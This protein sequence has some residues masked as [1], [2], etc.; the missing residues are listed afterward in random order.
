MMQ[1]ATEPGSGAG[2][3]P[4][5]PA[6]DTSQDWRA[7]L[8]DAY[9]VKDST[10]AVKEKLNLRA[11]PTLAKYKSVEELARGHIEATKMIGAGFKVPGA[12]AAPAERRAFYDKLGVPKDAAG[13]ADVKAPEGIVPEAF[14]AYLN[15]VALATGLTPQQ[16]QASVNFLAEHNARVHQEQVQRWGEAQETLRKEWGLNFDRN[17]DISARFVRDVM[18]KAG[19][20]EEGK[21]EVAEF[22]R[23]LD[24]VGVGHHPGFFRWTEYLAR[25]ATEDVFEPG[26]PDADASTASQDAQ[27]A[28]VAGKL[29]KAIPGTPEYATLREQHEALLKRRHGTEEVSGI[30]VQ[31]RR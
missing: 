29:W 13:Y 10:G 30:T 28:E 18:A 9:E 12:D 1:L 25:N 19:G 2:A 27:I 15:N 26:T 6:A 16:V 20:T 14:G 24:Q 17:V 23:L 7:A 5:T 8:P 4:P 21:A 3:T 22:F 11:D 31:P